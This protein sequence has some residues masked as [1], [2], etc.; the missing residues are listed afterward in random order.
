[1]EATVL[2]YGRRDLLDITPVLNEAASAIID[3]RF[4]RIVTTSLTSSQVAEY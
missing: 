3:V 1:M 2:T 4:S